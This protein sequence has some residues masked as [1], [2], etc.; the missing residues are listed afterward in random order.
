MFSTSPSLKFP[1]NSRLLIAVMTVFMLVTVPACKKDKNIDAGLSASQLYDAAKR[2]MDQQN[3]G[4]AV[5]AY[6]GLSTRFPFGR[7]TEQAQLELA[8]CHH[9]SGNPEAALSEPTPVTPT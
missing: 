2:Y 1:I 5:H 7:Y 8:Y 6:Q 9:K 4:R 3:W